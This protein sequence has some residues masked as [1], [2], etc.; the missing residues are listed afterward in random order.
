MED[1]DYSYSKRG[2]QFLLNTIHIFIAAY[3]ILIPL[4]ATNT[5]ILRDYIILSAFLWLH[6]ITH[7]D[8]CA[9]TILESYLMDLPMNETFFG[10]LLKPVYLVT[11]RE[12]YLVHGLLVVFALY[13]LRRKQ[14]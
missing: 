5:A 11:S 6:W 10:R 4:V 7:N 14:A 13:K 9:L 8:T 3:F 12:I 2:L 1:D